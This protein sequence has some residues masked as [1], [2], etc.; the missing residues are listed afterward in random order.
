MGGSQESPAIKEK[1][2]TTINKSS[3]DIMTSIEIENFKKKLQQ[4]EKKIDN[5]SEIAQNIREEVT[6]LQHI[7]GESFQRFKKLVDDKVAFI[8]SDSAL[9]PKENTKNV[10]SG[11]SLT[12]ISVTRYTETP[13]LLKCSAEFASES[14]IT[15][16]SE[17]DSIVEQN[18]QLERIIEPILETVIL[19]PTVSTNNSASHLEEPGCSVDNVDEKSS[20]RKNEQF[21]Y[22]IEQV[23]R[24]KWKHILKE[25]ANINKFLHASR[26]N[27]LKHEVHFKDLKFLLNNN[28]LTTFCGENDQWVLQDH[29][30]YTTNPDRKSKC[31]YFEN[32]CLNTIYKRNDSAVEK[33]SRYVQNDELIV[34][35]WLGK[36][37]EKGF[38][39]VRHF[40]RMK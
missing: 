15:Q 22:P 11:S 34:E 9:F 31:Y 19:F 2:R 26:D 3:T 37:N 23:I 24:G 33:T 20:E 17:R 8:L 4:F 36:D 35:T 10:C 1:I 30:D 16:S 13:I 14:A 32:N 18:Q 40:K 6:R 7:Q 21:D 27:G 38:T 25:P 39:C 12:T 29:K 5:I 28:K